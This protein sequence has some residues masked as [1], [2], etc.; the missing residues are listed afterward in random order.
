[1][2]N[3]D[4]SMFTG[5]G[6][7]LMDAD[8]RTFTNAIDLMGDTSTAVVGNP[9]CLFRDSRGTCWMSTMDHGI[10]KFK[11]SDRRIKDV[12]HIIAAPMVDGKL[13]NAFV[14][15]IREDDRG[16]IWLGT[17]GGGVNKYD[18]NTA[19]FIQF[20]TDNGLPNNVIYGV[21]VDAHDRIWFTSNAGISCLDQHTGRE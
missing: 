4:G 2:L 14:T 13:S 20:T 19:K 21:E 7:D 9:F 11:Y 3:P 6:L 12:E 5:W 17:Y 8:R 1:M 18:P 15:C 10:Y 16:N